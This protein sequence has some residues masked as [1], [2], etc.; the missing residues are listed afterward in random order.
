MCTGHSALFADRRERPSS[1]RV[2]SS[3]DPPR[4]RRGACPR[5]LVPH[6]S[7]CP[8]RDPYVVVLKDGAGRPAEL[9]RAHARRLGLSSRAVFDTALRGY[10]AELF[11]RPAQRAGRGPR[12]AR[13]GPGPPAREPSSSRAARS[14]QP[15]SIPSS[16]A[17][18]SPTPRIDGADERVPVDV[19]VI[20]TG[21]APHPDLNVVGGKNCGDGPDSAFA[22]ADNGHGTHVAGILAAK[23]NAFGGVGVAPGARIFCTATERCART[24]GVAIQ[25]PGIHYASW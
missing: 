15:P 2:L 19:A 8:G 4:P 22:V 13:P 16:P 5:P 11:A 23:D 24:R 21:I 25:G 14:L 12:R 17:T 1:P 18:E 6:P 9:A 20:D 3:Q 10:A 7:S